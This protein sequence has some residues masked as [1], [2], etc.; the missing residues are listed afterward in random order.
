MSWWDTPFEADYSFGGG[1][2]GQGLQMPSDWNTGGGYDLGY[3]PSQGQGLQMPS[4]WTSGSGYDFGYSP[5]QGL[6][7]TGGYTPTPSRGNYTPQ[8]QT[9]FAPNVYSMPGGG[10]TIGLQSPSRLGGTP[11]LTATPTSGSGIRMGSFEPVQAGAPTTAAPTGN[12]GI[13]GS[14][15][16]A[17]LPTQGGAQ[18][19]P[20]LDR[21]S[22]TLSD[23]EGWGERN[24]RTA[25]LIA[26]GVGA[27]A[28]Y[29]GQRKANQAAE[30]QLALQR[31]QLDKSNAMA[32]YWNTQSRQSGDEAR[33]LYN[34]QELAVR[35][36]AQQVASTG[37]QEQTARSAALKR[38]M[39]PAEAEAEARRVRLAGSTN[40]TTGYMTGLDTGR[41]AQQ[42]ALSSAK[43]LSMG[44]GMPADTSGAAAG[45]RA[46]AAQ[47]GDQLRKLLEFYTGDPTRR[48]LREREE[49]ETRSTAT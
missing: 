10:S 21:I 48:V 25:S 18:Q 7:L 11:G 27:L 32:D 20:I 24:P 23:I 43:G 8:T 13:T 22:G 6:G 35:G 42:S 14:F 12:T 29:A 15:G 39:T 34:P 5:S 30:Q 2:S 47:T 19:T 33:S 38:G 45:L 36:M 40:A 26:Q 1:S 49:V 31:A 9:S 41:G 44:Y 28:S 17:G 46:G 16:G 4:D 37:R 3:S